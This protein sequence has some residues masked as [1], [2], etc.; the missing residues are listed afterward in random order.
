MHAVLVTNDDLVYVADRTN[1]RLQVF[2]LDGTFVKEVFITRN[3]L[4]TEGTVHTFAVSPDK[5]QRFLYVVDGSNKAIRVLNRQTLE[6]CRERRRT[7][8]P[9]RPRVLPR[10][11]L[12]RRLEGQP[13]HRRSQQRPALLQVRIQ[14]HGAG[15]TVA[16]FRS[17]HRPIVRFA[18]L[19]AVALVARTA[20]AQAV[21][22]V[23][24]ASDDFFGVSKIHTFQVDDLGRGLCT[25][26]SSQR[27]WRPRTGRRPRVAGPAQR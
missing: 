25:H 7:R 5:E 18:F 6:I 4:Q 23:E 15:P 17:M 10:A 16:P 27:P 12:R 19:I 14:G 13:V 2:R 26:A 3:T 20:A 21:D 8:R 22:P 24:G 1:N 11:Q 9:Q